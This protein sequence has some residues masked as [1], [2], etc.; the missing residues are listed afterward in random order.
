MGS[1]KVI[2][3]E[4]KGKTRG[5]LSCQKVVFFSQNKLYFQIHLILGFYK[6]YEINAFITLPLSL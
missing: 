5:D 4:I 6:P 1:K 2:V 3:D